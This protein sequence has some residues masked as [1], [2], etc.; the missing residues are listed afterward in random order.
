MKERRYFETKIELRDEGE[1]KPS[2]IIGYPALYN[3]L[4][5]DLGGFREKIAEG[6]FTR[7][8][9]EGSDVRAL[10][11]HDPNYVLGRNKSGTLKLEEDGRGLR[12]EVDPPDTGWAND[13]RTS[14]SRGDINQMSFGFMVDRDNW[15]VQGGQNI[16]T[17]EE[18][19]LF[20]VSVVTYPAYPETSANVRSFFNDVGLEF[21]QIAAIIA[22][23]KHGLDVSDA[24][25]EV[26]KR[27]I[28]YLESLLKDGNQESMNLRKARLKLLEVENT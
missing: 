15:E 3:S 9:Q 14:M 22:R 10:M 6:A 23:S 1:D 7:T 5:E 20:D 18:V 24:D 2:S 16:R 27:S 21:D 4:S 28:G 12:M 11:N 17:L 25:R 8:L 19:E 13:L 26:V